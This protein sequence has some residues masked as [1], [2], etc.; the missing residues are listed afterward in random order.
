MSHVTRYRIIQV[1]FQGYDNFIVAILLAILLK[2]AYYLGLFSP[3]LLYPSTNFPDRARSLF[4]YSAPT[5]SILRG[6]K[7]ANIK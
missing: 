5:H 3:R 4:Q 6:H 7:S 2:I 1:S